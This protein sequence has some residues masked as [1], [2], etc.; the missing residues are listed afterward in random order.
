MSS[1]V[2]N[3]YPHIRLVVCVSVIFTPHSLV[4]PNNTQDGSDF[5][6]QFVSLKHSNSTYASVDNAPSYFADKTNQLLPPKK[7]T[8]L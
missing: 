7:F 5:Y 4:I 3:T 1:H 2:S 6:K 8:N